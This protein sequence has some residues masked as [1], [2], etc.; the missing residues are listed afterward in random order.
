MI[1]I[2]LIFS[3]LIKNDMLLYNL[4]YYELHNQN[5]IE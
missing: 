2:N 5:E 4:I 3:Q 1:A